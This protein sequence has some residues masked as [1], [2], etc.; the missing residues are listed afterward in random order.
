MLPDKTFATIAAVLTPLVCFIAFAGDGFRSDFIPD[1]MMN[2]Y[3]AWTLPIGD[4]LQ[5]N[6]LFFTN[7]YRPLGLLFYK[8]LFELFGLNPFPYRLVCLT[9]LLIN[10]GLLYLFSKCLSPSTEIATL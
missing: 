2:L 5:A 6:L 10:L 7:S 8:L 4:C 3:S 1:D 9:L